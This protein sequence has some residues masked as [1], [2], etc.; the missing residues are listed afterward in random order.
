MTLSSLLV[1]PM[2]ALMAITPLGSLAPDR[3]VQVGDSDRYVVSSR[4][5]QDGATTVEETVYAAGDQDIP[6]TVVKLSE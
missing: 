1:L 4:V 3:V 5:Y 2:S 6:D